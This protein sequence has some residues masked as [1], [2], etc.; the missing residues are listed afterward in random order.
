MRAIKGV[1]LTCDSAVKQILLTMNEKDPFVIEDLDDYHLVIKA[2][3]EY[4]VRRELEAEHKYLPC[5][6]LRSVCD[7]AHN[8]S[9]WARRYGGA[10]PVKIS[11]NEILK[12]DE[13]N[14]MTGLIRVPRNLPNSYLPQ[15][16]SFS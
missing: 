2:D 14:Y 6:G 5:C 15:G 4:R 13:R 16:V 7:A 10:L 12:V 3:E 11:S 8:L 9:D 1:L